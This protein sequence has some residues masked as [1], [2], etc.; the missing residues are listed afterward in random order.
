MNVRVSVYQHEVS[1]RGEGLNRDI[2][3]E[4]KIILWF[5]ERGGAGARLT[6][7]RRDEH[8][9]TLEARRPTKEHPLCAFQVSL[10]EQEPGVYHVD[11]QLTKPIH[12]G[13]QSI[14]MPQRRSL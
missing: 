7:G 10:D 2:D 3:L 12:F 5:R 4:G 9:V 8:D 14:P 11:L 13:H 6:L 1:I